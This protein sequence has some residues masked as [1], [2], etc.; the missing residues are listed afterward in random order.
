MKIKI[1]LLA[2]VLLL[3]A[4]CFPLSAFSQGSLTPPG[5]P[6]PT[7]KTLAQIEP[8]TPIASAP[9]TITVPGSYYL[10]TNL[11]VAS[12]TAITIAT[13]GVTLDLNGFTI[14]STAPSATGYGIYINNAL[15]NL[16]IVNGFIQGGV[17][18]NG[19]GVYSGSGF[20]SGI[21]GYP[22]NIHVSG[23]SVSSC[24]YYGVFL[25]NGDATVVESCTVRTVG[26][27]GILASTIKASAAKDCGAY[28]IYGEQVADCRGQ[29][30]GSSSGINATTA[31]NCYGTSASGYGLHAGTAE[32]CYGYSSSSYGL[33]ASTAQNCQGYS[34]SGYGL[35]ATTAQNCYGY[36]GGSG[37]GLYAS[38]IAIGCLGY[39][40][41]G[42]GLNAYIANSCRGINNTGTAQIITYKYNMP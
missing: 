17:T 18:N 14:A 32:N 31:L 39:S 29:S 12:G 8:R 9:L 38:D 7:M 30:T 25:G 13:N 6:A 28:A 35:Y 1:H 10:T 22:Q 40:F 36:S 21:F 27:Y 33:Y 26:G 24:L 19:S 16:A 15:R 11:T 34:S 42:T 5:A 37:Y 4:F 41:S 2:A 20:G 3:S 23:V